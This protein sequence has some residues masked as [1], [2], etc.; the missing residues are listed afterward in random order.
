[1]KR[2]KISLF[3]LSF[4]FFGLGSVNAVTFTVNQNI[5]NL[6]AIPNCG[7]SNLVSFNEQSSGNILTVRLDVNHNIDGSIVGSPWLVN[8]IHNQCWRYVI[9]HV[10]KMKGNFPASTPEASFQK[11]NHWL[12]GAVYN[13][14]SGSAYYSLDASD[15]AGLNL[16][17]GKKAVRV[18]VKYYYWGN[19]PHTINLNVASN[20]I[21]MWSR[22][23]ID[24]ANN[25]L[26]CL[27]PGIAGC[28][29]YNNCDATMIPFI[30]FQTFGGFTFYTY[31]A[32]VSG[33]SGNFSYLWKVNNGVPFGA[34]D[35]YSFFGNPGTVKIKVTDNVTGCVY[36]SNGPFKRTEEN[37]LVQPEETIFSFRIGPNPGSVNAPLNV[38]YT[39]PAADILTVDL[40]D[41]SGRLV[42]NLAHDVNG[43]MGENTLEVN[44]EG[45]SSGIYFV[46]LNAATSG[47]LM[48]KII[49]KD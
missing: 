13:N 16:S 42:Q 25:T 44:P 6:S 31:Y 43:A 20:Y 40:Y 30:S 10:Y 35:H 39:L 12:Q 34:G 24:G 36:F 9:F 8:T 48:K 28:F 33:G 46:K 37:E 32:N 19:T 4:L 7:S 49:L 15:L 45:L 21:P 41:L 5:V 1:M 14:G 23:N 27:Q 11:Y 29:N 47:A 26:N 3:L 17:S 18:E 22:A 2:L 38:K